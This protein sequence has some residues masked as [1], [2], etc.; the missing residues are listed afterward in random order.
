MENNQENEKCILAKYDKI[1]AQLLWL[2]YEKN[3]VVA[4]FKNMVELFYLKRQ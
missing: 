2:V 3:K 4:E 1:M